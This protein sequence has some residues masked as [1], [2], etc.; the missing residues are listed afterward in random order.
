M[1]YASLSKRGKDTRLNSFQKKDHK[2]PVLNICKMKS[3][4]LVIFII[5]SSNTFAQT[6]AKTDTSAPKYVMKQYWFVMLTKGNNRNHDSLTAA[7]IQEGHMANITAMANS[8]KLLVA[9]PFGDDTQ[10]RGILTQNI[11]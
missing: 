2:L 5:L 10:W 6:S 9:G 3:I 1:Y 4:S 7:K 11:H 8:H